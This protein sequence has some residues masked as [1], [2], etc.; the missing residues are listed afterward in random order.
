LEF[1]ERLSPNHDER[2][3]G[4]PVDMLV[5]HY[6]GMQ[7]FD[8]ALDR[9]AD[10]A[11]KV[12]AHYA[13]G[14]DGVIYRMVAEDQRAWHA[15]V[16]SWRGHTDINGRSIG[17]ELENKGHEYGYENF[18][19]AQMSAL[20]GLCREILARHPIPSRNVV[21]HSD[22]APTRK[23]DPGE[24]FDWAR[25]AAAGIGL[26]P[27]PIDREVALTPCDFLYG[28]I[29]FGYDLTDEAGAFRAFHRRFR[30][31]DVDG[32]VNADSLAVLESLLQIYE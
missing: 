4:T 10:P 6:T 30:P 5:I 14:R 8:D 20:I 15:G 25:M 7:S 32:P 28:L 31:M 12:S 17:I 1:I 13:I 11:A 2:P 24:K 18:A 22:V 26:W 3:A 27:D 16:S 9:L 29:K 21:G 19:D 23:V